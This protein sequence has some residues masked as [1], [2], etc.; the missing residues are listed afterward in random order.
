[1]K[2]GCPFLVSQILVCHDH[3]G[4]SLSVKGVHAEVHVTLDLCMG[5]SAPFKHAASDVV[6]QILCLLLTL[7]EVVL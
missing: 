1:M 7:K 6:L 4:T 5:L 3:K 2:V